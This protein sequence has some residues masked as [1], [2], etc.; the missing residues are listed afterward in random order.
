MISALVTLLVLA[1]L[2]AQRRSLSA[3]GRAGSPP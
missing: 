3:T 1:L 2:F